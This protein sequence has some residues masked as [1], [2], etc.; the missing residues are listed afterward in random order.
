MSEENTVTFS[1]MEDAWEKAKNDG[2]TGS[3]EEFEAL[4]E[5]AAKDI[6]AKNEKMDAESLETVAGGSFGSV[7]KDIGGWCKDHP[8]LIAGIGGLAATAI[9]YGV[10]R[11]ANSGSGNQ[12]GSEEASYVSG[13]STLTVKSYISLMSHP[14]LE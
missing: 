3:L 2:Y 6:A 8:E 7:M 1:S 12:Q 5:K 11:Y 9:G 10:Y 13:S 14:G 4:C